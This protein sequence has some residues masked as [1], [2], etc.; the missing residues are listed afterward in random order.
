[1]TTTTPRSPSRRKAPGRPPPSS[2]T[3]PVRDPRE[4]LDNLSLSRKEGWRDM[5]EAAPREPPEMLS[6]RQ[7]S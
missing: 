2:T 1:M 3:E 6:A 5:V 4:Y 7:G